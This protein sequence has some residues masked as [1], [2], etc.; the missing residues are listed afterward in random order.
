MRNMEVLDDLDLWLRQRKETFIGADEERELDCLVHFFDGFN[1]QDDG[2]KVKTY[3]KNEKNDSFHTINFS[4]LTLLASIL[5]SLTVKR[6][7]SDTLKMVKKELLENF[8]QIM[9]QEGWIHKDISY[10]AGEIIAILRNSLEDN[11]PEKEKV[12]AEIIRRNNLVSVKGLLL[13]EY[14]AEYDIY[15]KYLFTEFLDKET[16]GAY[17]DMIGRDLEKR[18]SVAQADWRD[19][20]KKV[21]NMQ[22]QL[23][24]MLNQYNELNRNIRKVDTEIGA[25]KDKI[26][27]TKLRLEMAENNYRNRRVIVESAEKMAVELEE[28]LTSLKESRREMRNRL[29]MQGLVIDFGDKKDVTKEIFFNGRKVKD[30]ETLHQEMKKSLEEIDKKIMDLEKRRNLHLTDLENQRTSL[31]K[32][33]EILKNIKEE[34]SIVEKHKDEVEMKLSFFKQE[35]LKISSKLTERKTVLDDLKREARTLKKVYDNLDMER[36]RILYI[37]KMAI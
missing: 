28:N 22:A 7:D 21:D 20:Q 29:D 15:S 36:K 18:C 34:M 16:S 13:V 9:K 23:D 31:K 30:I 35:Y 32:E 1:S 24:L 33:E 27:K 2:Y 5:R 26:S 8:I 10:E 11:I 4:P 19:A 37:L 25:L 12:I 14:L 6:G 3:L 17:R